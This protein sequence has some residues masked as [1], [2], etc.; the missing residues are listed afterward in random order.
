MERK[1][2]SE[3]L[4]RM[5][6]LFGYKRGV[7]ISEQN[8]V[9]QSN[10]PENSDVDV[11]TS[12]PNWDGNSSGSISMTNFSKDSTGVIVNATNVPYKNELYNLLITKGIGKNLPYTYE[13]PK[14][15]PTPPQYSDFEF[16]GKTFPFNDNMIKMD[17]G[18]VKAEM[19]LNLIRDT[20]INNIKKGGL[21]SMKGIKITGF[22]DSARP[23]DKGPKGIELDHDSA[24]D[25]NLKKIGC[26]KYCGL[27]DDNEKNKFLALQ[28]A[29]NMAVNINSKVSGE[30]SLVTDK[31]FKNPNKNVD[32]FRKSGGKLPPSFFIIDSYANDVEYTESRKGKRS[33]TIEVIPAEPINTPGSTET[34]KKYITV[35]PTPKKGTINYDGVILSVSEVISKAGYSSY[36]V[37]YD[38]NFKS[39][40]KSGK[41][42]NFS[43]PG[44]M[45]GKTM[46]TGKIDGDSIT[47][48]GLNWGNFVEYGSSDSGVGSGS[49]ARM[50]WI[51][52]KSVLC[53]VDIKEGDDDQYAELLNYRVVLAEPQN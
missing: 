41:I 19:L 45:N 22:A 12:S 17:T 1:I 30:L 31:D 21:S 6:Y 37:D 39:L 4:G 43:V 2:L 15:N 36:V 24:L 51:T 16:I 11:S 29:R 46:V 42:P 3:E 53:A 14:D 28:R 49:Y 47:I 8:L 5:A 38:E 23:T 13:E 7:V 50:R 10:D 52:E 35:V 33:V 20:I 44:Q 26:K 34:E 27:R 48:D 32:D 9:G 40:I 18:N 25:E